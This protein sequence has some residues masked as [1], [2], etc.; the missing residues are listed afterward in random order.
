MPT[1]AHLYRSPF[2]LYNPSIHLV[3]SLYLPTAPISQSNSW[4]FSTTLSPQFQLQCNFLQYF[5]SSLGSSD[6]SKQRHRNCE[7]L[8]TREESYIP[9]L[10]L[11][12]FLKAGWDSD[13]NKDLNIWIIWRLQAVHNSVFNS[14]ERKWELQGCAL[15][16]TF[17]PTHHTSHQSNF[18]F[19]RLKEQ[20]L[21][22]KMQNWT[23]FLLPA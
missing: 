12:F 22:W 4:G 18:R 11:Y 19:K 23:L 16:C 17:T 20:S 3:P 15:T 2:S 9:A 5:S 21:V 6:N 14:E 8:W 13:T 10:L 1:R 7:S